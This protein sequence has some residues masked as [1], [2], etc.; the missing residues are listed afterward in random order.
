MQAKLFTTSSLLPDII[1]QN[2]SPK[3]TSATI[4]RTRE[5]WELF[6]GLTIQPTFRNATTH[7]VFPAK[8]RL[9]KAAQKF[10]TGDVSPPRSGKCFLLVKA[11]SLARR[12]TRSSAQVWRVK[13]HQH[14]ISVLVP[15]TSYRRETSHWVVASWN[16]YYL[17]RYNFPPTNQTCLAT[18]QVVTGCVKLFVELC[19]KICI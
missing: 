16:Q 3:V 14:W 12:P 5:T 17:S 6:C 2:E 19:N 1:K 11:N 9:K 4:I 8:C 18:N 15:Q 10:H 7:S 13:G